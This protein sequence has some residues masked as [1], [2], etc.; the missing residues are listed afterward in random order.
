MKKSARLS[1]V[2]ARHEA[3]RPLHVAAVRLLLLTGCRKGEILTLK[4]SYYREGKLFLPDSKTG[5]RTVWLSSAARK[6][7]DA[8]PESTSQMFP[9][10]RGQ[11]L[12]LGNLWRKVRTEANL[13][14]VR[15]HDLRHSYASIAMLRGETV[16]TI[17][18]LLGHNDPATT[19]KYTHLSDAAVHDAVRTVAPALNG[20]E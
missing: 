13:R 7:L 9:A 3:D 5:P 8:L 14:D 12:S 2:L 1:K 18:K 17:G 4:W 20:E 15:L 16:L 11:M 10:R 19:L 6:V